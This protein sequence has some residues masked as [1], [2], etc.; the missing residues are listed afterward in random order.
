MAFLSDLREIYEKTFFEGAGSG[1]GGAVTRISSASYLRLITFRENFDP[2]FPPNFS[3][4]VLW[5]RIVMTPPRK[6]I[7]MAAYP[8]APT[9]E[10]NVACAG[11]LCSSIAAVCVVTGAC[12]CVPGG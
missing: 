8:W 3:L 11:A 12:V 1:E 6:K 9:M 10:S 2:G 5:A 4:Q 7:D